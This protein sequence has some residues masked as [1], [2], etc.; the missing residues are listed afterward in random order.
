MFVAYPVHV[1]IESW[2]RI[3]VSKPAGDYQDDIHPDFINGDK[4]RDLNFKPVYCL[5]IASSGNKNKFFIST[6]ILYCDQRCC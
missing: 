4:K 6:T 5:R 3:V 1:L 2:C